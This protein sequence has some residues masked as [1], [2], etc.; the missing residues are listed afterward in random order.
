MIL[1]N[2][3][4]HGVSRTAKVC[5][6][7]DRTYYDKEGAERSAWIVIIYRCAGSDWRRADLISSDSWDEELVRNVLAGVLKSTGCKTT[8][9]KV[10]SGYSLPS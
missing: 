8:G 7:S 6:S 10:A 1:P 3:H 9:Y 2:G 5:S 4:L